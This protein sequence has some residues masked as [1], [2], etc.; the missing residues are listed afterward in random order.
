VKKP[1]PWTI[2]LKHIPLELK[3][4]AEEPQ[5]ELPKPSPVPAQYTKPSYMIN[6]TPPAAASTYSPYSTGPDTFQTM[7][8]QTSVSATK[9]TPPPHPI[10]TMAT[11]MPSMSHDSRPVMHGME[12]GHRPPGYEMMYYH[13]PS[14]Q[15]HMSTY[16]NN[17]YGMY[18]QTAAKRTPQHQ[19]E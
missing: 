9:Y 11:G 10:P 3:A 7:T 14:S 18:G 19:Q 16:Y 1:A 6:T 12:M 2:N 15:T 4:P 5:R 13:T 17:P 8:P